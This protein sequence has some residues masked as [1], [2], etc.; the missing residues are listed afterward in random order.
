[1]LLLF[2]KKL[3]LHRLSPHKRGL[4][5]RFAHYQLFAVSIDARW[6]RFYGA[7]LNRVNIPKAQRGFF[8]D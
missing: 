1:L 6:N 7:Y 2:R 4:L 5:R 3:R 8:M